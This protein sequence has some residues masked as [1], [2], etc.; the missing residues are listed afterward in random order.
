M[1]VAKLASIDTTSKDL[2]QYDS[3]SFESDT[4]GN[5]QL[6]LTLRLFI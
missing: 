6:V 1:S 3:I 2:Q 5:L 4:E